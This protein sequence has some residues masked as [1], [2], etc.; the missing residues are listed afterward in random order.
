MSGDA[1]TMR[2]LASNGLR[3]VESPVAGRLATSISI[4]FCAGARHETPDEVGAA[5]LLEHMAFKG[6][7]G[8][9][10]ARELNR[11]S[12]RLGAELNAHTSNDYVEFY[13]IVRAEWA[14]Q[15]A[16]MLADLCA[17]P[18]LDPALLDGERDVV[19][20]EI[21][22]EDE[23]P[24]SA[25]D[26]RLAAA[27]FRGHRLATPITGRA[28]DVERLTHADLV[29]F[30]ERRWSPAAGVVVLGGNLDHV[31]R[32]R[33]DELLLAIPARPVPPPPAPIAP[34][35]PRIELEP[36]DGDVAHLRVAY[37]VPGLDL[38][39]ARQRA[40]AEV[41]SQLLGGP[42]GSRL[43][44]E[45][46][47]QRGLCYAID[48]S[49]WG[50]PLRSMLSVDAS[51]QGERLGEAFAL[52][53]QIVADLRADGPTEEEA[54][55]GR[56]YAVGTFALSFD[57][58]GARAGHAIETLMEYGDEQIDPLAYLRAIESVT[59]AD[60]AELAARVA[61]DPCIGCAGDVDARAFGR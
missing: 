22:D 55:R 39:N 45:L 28:E 11:S 35:E 3:V 14:M 12:E 8:H 57:S 54:H 25:A 27:L 24:A 53:E 33:L 9:P 59:R 18:L 29:A 17:R 50:Y 38:T 37:D 13:A 60:L 4:A 42:M 48:G 36:R 47:E 58:A 41:F 5:H 49:V 16:A 46:R 30:R 19:L 32:E 61:P 51:L 44:D 20:Q 31:D 15:I 2:T 40:V 34:F 10:T 43:V 23:E 56:A 21:A 7:A 1:P 6:T 26:R 52:I